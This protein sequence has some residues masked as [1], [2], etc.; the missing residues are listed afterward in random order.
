MSLLS[1]KAMK[2]APSA[3]ASASL[4]SGGSSWTSGSYVELL[5]ATGAAAAFVGLRTNG[6]GAGNQQFEID[7][8]T[9][10]SGSESVIATVRIS[11]PNPSNGIG[12]YTLPIPVTGIANGGRIAARARCNNISQAIAIT[13]F[14]VEDIDSDDTTMKP[15]NAAP[16]AANNASVTPSGTA[17]N[18]S[19]WVELT[20][21][22]ADPSAIAG[23]S[24]MEPNIGATPVDVE[25]DIGTGGAGSETVVTTLRGGAYGNSGVALFALNLPV[26]L[27]V[28]G[29][30]RVAYRMRKTST[31][32]TAWSAALMYYADLAAP[33]RGYV[34][35]MTW[36]W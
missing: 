26:V 9:G 34:R 3:A 29:G 16:S 10:A 31:N 4:T 14:Y 24:I 1:T 20:A 17:W 2:M 27:P 22:L 6:G 5:S 23:L 18:N 15:L 30:P 21:A 12:V 28:T 36:G 33:A 25:M 13:A 32:T 8:A 11:A 7:I 35:V 19:S